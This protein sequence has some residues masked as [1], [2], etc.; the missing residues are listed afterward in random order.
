MKSPQ[1]TEQNNGNRVYNNQK[2]AKYRSVGYSS[3]GDSRGTYNLESIHR[4]VVETQDIP[5]SI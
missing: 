5:Q 4:S 2:L 3:P 1:N